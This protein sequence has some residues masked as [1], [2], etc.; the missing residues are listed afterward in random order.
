MDNGPLLALVRPQIDYEESCRLT[1]YPDS[2]GIPT[3]GWG[4][5][6]DGVRLGMTCTQAQADGW[7]DEHLYAICDSLDQLLHWWRTLELPRQ[8]VL[9]EMAYQMG[10]AGLLAFHRT[11]GSIQDG[12]WQLAYAGMLASQWALRDSPT[13]AKREATQMLTGVVAS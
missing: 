8:A 2:K 9:V 4:R 5:A 13:R 7:R 3:I 12:R 6:D 10:V 11:L 1:A